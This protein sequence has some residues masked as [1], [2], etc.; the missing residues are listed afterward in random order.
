MLLSRCRGP[1]KASNGVLLA[2]ADAGAGAA[3]IRLAGGLHPGQDGPPSFW[4]FPER[5]HAFERFAL[6][7]WLMVRR[8][9][10]GPV[11]G[12]L[13]APGRGLNCRGKRAMQR[14]GSEGLTVLWRDEWRL[15]APVV[16]PR[17]V[18]APNAKCQPFLFPTRDIP[19]HRRRSRL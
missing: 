18:A 14:C 11:Q 13:A 1:G 12:T 5:G 15:P 7:R 10:L 8:R 6:R 9:G 2:D 4:Q 17:A 19:T 16:R 3:A